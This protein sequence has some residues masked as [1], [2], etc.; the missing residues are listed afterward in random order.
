[1]LAAAAITGIPA[2][3]DGSSPEAPEADAVVPVFGELL[4]EVIARYKGTRKPVFPEIDDELW[5]VID[6]PVSSVPGRMSLPRH[7]TVDKPRMRLYVC[8]ALG[9]TLARYPVCASRNRGQKRSEDDCRTPEGTF[10]VVGIYNST[11]W[12]YK[13]TDDKCYGPFFISLF[14][15]RFWGIGI[16]GTNAPYSVPGRRSHG[17]MRMHNESI[18]KVKALVNKDTRVTVLPDPEPEEEQ[19]RAASL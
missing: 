1:M 10:K 2:A 4:E 8:N 3:A 19:A 15:P 17:C 12:T 11:D 7:V 6:S 5:D 16:H 14:T 18:V 9:D 13:D